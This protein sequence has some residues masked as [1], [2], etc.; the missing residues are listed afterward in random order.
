M[1]VSMRLSVQSSSR[2]FLQKLVPITPHRVRSQMS[3]MRHLII[4]K[5]TTPLAE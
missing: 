4:A 3:S 2:M 1:C 5:L